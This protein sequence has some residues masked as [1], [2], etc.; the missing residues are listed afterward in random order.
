MSSTCPFLMPSFTVNNAALC[1]SSHYTLL[2]KM[3]F[4]PLLNQFT[5]ASLHKGECWNVIG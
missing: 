1:L 4:P 3:S 2:T 5:E